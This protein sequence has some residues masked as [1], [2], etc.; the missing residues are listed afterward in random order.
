MLIDFAAIRPRFIIDV[1]YAHFYFRRRA[2]DGSLISLT[3]ALTPAIADYLMVAAATPNMP[4]SPLPP[5]LPPMPPCRRLY[6]IDDA[7]AALI[8]LRFHARLLMPPCHER[9]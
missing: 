9:Y 1:Y 5:C 4:L 8:T 3:D 7:V 2:I 6:A